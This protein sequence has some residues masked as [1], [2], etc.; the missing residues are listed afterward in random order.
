MNE[1]NVKEFYKKQFE[2][3]NYDINT[4]SWLEQVAKE[5]QEQVGIHFKRC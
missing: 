1:L 2:L 5:V 4:E 3:S